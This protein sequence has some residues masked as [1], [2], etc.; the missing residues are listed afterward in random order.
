MHFNFFY[1]KSVYIFSFFIILLGCQLKEPQQ[2]H[3]IL[4]LE[5]RSAKLQIDISNQND[6][7]KEIGHP[8]SKSINDEKQGVIV[9]QTNNPFN[10]EFPYITNNK[11]YSNG[12]AFKAIQNTMLFFPST[13]PH[14]VT[15]NETDHERVV[16]S[17]NLHFS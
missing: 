6:V 7:I 5:N 3:G 8:H 2:N 9:F 11:E 1:L 14:K 16:L 10:I 4:F 17:F 12:V 13:L 15:I